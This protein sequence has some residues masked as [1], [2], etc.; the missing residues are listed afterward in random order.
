MHMQRLTSLSIYILKTFLCFYNVNCN[1]VQQYWW[2]YSLWT[3]FLCTIV[4]YMSPT[5]LKHFRPKA[6]VK[7]GAEYQNNVSHFGL[8]RAYI[9]I[10]KSNL[11]YTDNTLFLGHFYGFLRFVVWPNSGHFWRVYQSHYCASEGTFPISFV[12]VMYLNIASYLY[13]KQI[14]SK[15]GNML[16]LWTMIFICVYLNLRCLCECPTMTLN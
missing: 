7:S 13:G 16:Y 4:P 8:K 6:N 3:S 14:K 2:T 5:L 11:P 9:N 12:N 1:I 10:R 15:L